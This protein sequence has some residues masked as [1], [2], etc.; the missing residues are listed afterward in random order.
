MSAPKRTYKIAAI[1]ADGVGKEV[2]A[3][4]RR[5][6]D[7]LAEHSN[8]TFA[9]AWDEF[10]WGS[11]Y[12]ARNGRMMAE[13]GL[14]TLKNYDAIYFGAVG[15]PTVPDWRVRRHTPSA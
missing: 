2:V 13:D 9:F 11:E 6:L 5:V 15:W 12:Y 3:A 10:D 1:P 4:G 7:A 14:E 8:G